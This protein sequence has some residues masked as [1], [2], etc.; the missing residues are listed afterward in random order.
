VKRFAA[1]FLIAGCAAPAPRDTARLQV[2]YYDAAGALAD[3]HALA[4]RVDER[5]VAE[6]KGVQ[7][8]FT[9]NQDYTVSL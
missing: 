5:F 8:R 9:L 2:R 1:L 6:V 4:V 3:T 7:Y